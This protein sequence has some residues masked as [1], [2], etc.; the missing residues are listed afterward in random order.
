MKE[1]KVYGA[2][3]LGNP[4]FNKLVAT[5]Y[6]LDMARDFVGYKTTLGEYF[7]I[8]CDGEVIEDEI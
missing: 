8:T 5:F 6:D 4:N 7:S 1:Y 3:G 2:Y